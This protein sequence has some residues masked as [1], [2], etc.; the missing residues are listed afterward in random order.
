MATRNTTYVVALTAKAAP[1]LIWAMTIPANRRSEKARAVEDDR[2][3]CQRRRQR[4]SIDQGRDQ[5]QARRLGHG[6]E[7]AEEQCECQQQLDRDPLGIDEDS[8]QG[9]LDAAGNL[10]HSD[11]ADPVAPVGERTGYR[12][13]EYDR[14]EFGHRHD[15]EPGAGMGQGP[16]EPADRHPL[17]PDADERDGIA[18][19]VD[20]IIAVG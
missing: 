11:D 20:A 12:A 1:T 7:D 6:V 10:C 13:E 8:E 9:C 15:A 19:S 2:V 17:H 3:D 5:C 18:A 14:E 4:R 16:G